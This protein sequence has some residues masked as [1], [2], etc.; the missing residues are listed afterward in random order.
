MCAPGED[1]AAAAASSK[2]RAAAPR[3]ADGSCGARFVV[4]QQEF[5][6]QFYHVYRHRLEQLRPALVAAA[7]EKWGQRGGEPPAIRERVLDAPL[8]ETSVIV[9]TLGKTMK[10]RS[11]IL[12]EYLN[13]EKA[14]S[15]AKL[16]NFTS[17]DDSL[18]LEDETGRVQLTGAIEAATGRLVAGVVIALLGTAHEGNEFHVA[19]FCFAGT[20]APAMAEAGDAAGDAGEDTYVA[21]VSGLRMGRNEESLLATKMMVDYL[22]GWDAPQNGPAEQSALQPERIV[23]TIVA[24]NSFDIRPVDDS[25]LTP[26]QL[27]AK[28][29]RGTMTYE[30]NPVKELDCLLAQLGASMPV[31]LM[32]GATDPANCSLPQQPLYR[33]FVAKAAHYPSL[34]TVTNPAEVT[35]GRT[36]GD[37]DVA[38]TTFLG[39]SG[40]NVDDIARYTS[41]TEADAEPLAI[42]GN[43]LNWRHLAP[44]APDTLA[45]YPFTETDPFVLDSA[46]DVFFAGNQAA[47]GTAVKDNVRLVAVPDFSTT[48]TIVLLNLRTRECHPVVFQP[49]SHA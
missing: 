6:Q 35:V 3:V 43:L 46:P 48:R 49:P 32:P 7:Q 9:G 31:D 25:Q 13:E 40:Q 33:H 14:A 4:E 5:K 24:G 30:M 2:T 39:T 26:A 16:S 8:G 20:P 22:T 15:S 17:D 21:L 12:D 23:R 18:A 19:D 47:F 34:S 45:L 37:G 36:R 10:L 1:A 42:L 38:T 41:P 28:Q 11:G 29:V 27:R 44:T